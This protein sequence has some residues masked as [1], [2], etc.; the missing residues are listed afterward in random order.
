MLTYL[1]Y[2]NI[3]LTCYHSMLHCLPNLCCKQE[4][5]QLSTAYMSVPLSMNGIKVDDMYVVAGRSILSIGGAV[6]GHKFRLATSHLESPCGHNQMFSKERV[7]QCKEACSLSQHTIAN[8]QHNV[9]MGM[10]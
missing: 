6:Q 9:S 1:H 7:A 2:D 8:V 3:V 5:Y 4:A 10:H